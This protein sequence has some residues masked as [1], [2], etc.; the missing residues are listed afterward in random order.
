MPNQKFIFLLLGLFKKTKSTPLKILF[1]VLAL[2]I[3]FFYGDFSTS[4]QSANSISSQ[5]ILEKISDGD[6]LTF[7][8]A[9]C[10]ILYIDTPEKFESDKL[11]RNSVKCGIDIKRIIDAG[12][13]ST[14]KANE[15]LNIGKTYEIKTYEKDKYDRS[16]CQVKIDENLDFGEEMIKSGYAVLFKNGEG[17]K[18]SNIKNRLISIQNSAKK[19]GSGLWGEYSDVMECTSY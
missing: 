2:L 14:K 1:G 12:E 6:T 3:I 10:R 9:K 19:N 16:L 5:Q 15:L 8:L 17:I 13:L 18:E 11:Y 7:S 4:T